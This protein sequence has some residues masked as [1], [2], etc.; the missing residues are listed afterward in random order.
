MPV[1]DE[2]QYLRA[3]LNRTRAALPGSRAR[4]L[5]AKIQ[6][7]VLGAGFYRNARTIVLYAP[8]G[9]EVATGAILDDA[10]A[11]AR[12]VLY[13]RLEPGAQVLGLAPVR[14]RAELGPGAFGI[15]EPGPS[16]GAADPGWLG[17]SLVV[18]P[19]VAFSPRG[20]RLGRGGGH[21]DRLLSEL[22][23]QTVTVGLAYSFGLLDRI[24]QEQWDRR[25]DYVVT[26]S[27]I[28]AA[29]AGVGHDAGGR[30]QGGVPR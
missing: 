10:L 11:A 14:S 24:P 6:S 29:E 22:A 16:S 28:Y 13:P 27:A 12:T 4:A 20:E 19:G 17:E 5:S 15:P 26:E 25:L 8:L 3:V 7:L 23:P 1:A 18:V 9:N 30:Q 21:Y 2:K